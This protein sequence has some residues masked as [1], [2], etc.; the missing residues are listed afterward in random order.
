MF[1]HVADPFEQL[2]T[3][4]AL[5]V[6]LVRMDDEV[7]VQ[8]VLSHKRLLA[9]G[10]LMRTVACQHNVQNKNVSFPKILQNNHTISFSHST[11]SMFSNKDLTPTDCR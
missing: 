6:A 2:S 8:S 7:L 11:K 5:E 3:L 1:S 4:P 10:A 9:H